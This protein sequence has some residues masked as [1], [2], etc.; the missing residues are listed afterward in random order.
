MANLGEPGLCQ[1]ARQMQE[2]HDPLIGDAILDEEAPSVGL[3]QAG[4]MQCAQMLGGVRSAQG[5]KTSQGCH[6]A[7]ALAQQ[8]EQLE[9]PGRRQRLADAGKLRIDAVLEAARGRFH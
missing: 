9:S 5:G 2:S 7:G 8:P 1:F 3:D 4:A 6:R